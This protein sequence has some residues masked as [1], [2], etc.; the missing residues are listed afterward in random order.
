MRARAVL[1]LLIVVCAFAAVAQEPPKTPPA[2]KTPRSIP[3]A[4]SSITVDG[5]LSDAAW[6][7]AAKYETWYETNP[8][9]NVEP[10]V[11]TVGYVTYD[12]RF[13]Y[14]GIESF[15]PNPKEISAPYADHDQI[16]G[17]IDDYVGVILDT[18]NDGK[19]AILFL[20]TARGTQYD[21][22]TN[23]FSG[24]DS[25][26]D[27][28]WDSVSK[29][30]DKG[31]TMELRIPFSSLRYDGGDPQT[32]GM[33][34]YRNLPR[35]RRYQMF[36]E[37]L[38]R[39]SNCFVCNYGKITD[40]RG[41]PSGGHIVAAP[42]VTAAAVG[43]RRGALGTDVVTSPVEGDAGLDLK[44]TPTPDMAIDATLN[45]DFSQV[46]SDVAVVTTN[47][48]FAIFFPE[49]RPFFLEGID[50]FSTPIQA[51]YTR[52]ITAPRWG[53]R[54][55]GKFGDN[56]YTLLVA[57]DR[58]GGTVILPSPEGSGFA[59]QNDNSY[60]MIGRVKRDY[61]RSYVSVLATTREVSGGAHNRVLGPDF[62]WR[63]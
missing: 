34:L 26:P 27:L 19:S 9:D 23:D 42:Y 16:S 18:R 49:K 5:V 22:V 53:L 45:P 30:H 47:E 39:N 62:Q 7:T 24:E 61:G 4:A 6:Q 37:R 55:T 3:K 48:R 63:I 25:S 54:S 41:L 50:L 11:K 15:D 32:W 29:I 51:V 31:W 43:E 40:L 52:S 21:A 28:F 12:E 20:V 14:V 57:D 13:F 33:I 8:G 35:D 2:Q 59:D 17:N 58:G 38:P 1:L 56:A 10:R 36:T 60:A 46:E 44:W